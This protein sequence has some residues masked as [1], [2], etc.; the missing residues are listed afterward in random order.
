MSRLK[1]CRV[2]EFYELEFLPV[3]RQCSREQRSKMTV[4]IYGR[5]PANIGGTV[6]LS[7]GI[8]KQATVSF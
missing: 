5:T 3:A 8:Q 7:R 1:I 4:R 6:I 2:K